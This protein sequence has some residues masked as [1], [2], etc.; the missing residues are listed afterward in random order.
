MA[1]GVGGTITNNLCSL[2]VKTTCIGLIGDDGEG[3]ELIKALE[4]VGADTAHMVKTNTLCTVLIP[5]LC[6]S[7]GTALIPK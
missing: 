7:V 3:Y 2:G 6:A 5:S 4:K 1:A